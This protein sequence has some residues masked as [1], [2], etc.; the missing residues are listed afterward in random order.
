MRLPTI[1]YINDNATDN[2][3]R[4]GAGPHIR[5]LVPSPL[6]PVRATM[7]NPLRFHPLQP[8]R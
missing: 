8:L 1:S 4:K 3:F 5:R 7:S 6:L 2:A